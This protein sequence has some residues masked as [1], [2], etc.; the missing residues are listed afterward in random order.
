MFDS[1]HCKS[2]LSP[3]LGFFFSEEKSCLESPDIEN[4]QWGK[5]P[6]QETREGIVGPR[7]THKVGRWVHDNPTARLRGRPRW[8]VASLCRKLPPTLGTRWSQLWESKERKR[9][10]TSV[11]GRASKA[12]G[13][14][15]RMCVG[16]ASNANLFCSSRRWRPKLRG[17]WRLRRRTA[18]PLRVTSVRA[19]AWEG[20]FGCE[21]M[22][23]CGGGGQESRQLTQDGSAAVWRHQHFLKLNNRGLLTQARLS[24][25][26]WD[27]RPR[28]SASE[29]LPSCIRPHQVVPPA[30]GATR[31]RSTAGGAA[32][33]LI[34]LARKFL[35]TFPSKLIPRL[36][37]ELLLKSSPRGHRRGKGIHAAGRPRAEEQ[38]ISTASAVQ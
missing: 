4:R 32:N 1:S 37:H 14:S 31:G 18:R 13:H 25:S 26:L 17:G 5:R 29:A 28:R 23:V 8:A 12:G 34:F 30:I 10:R 11:Y 19:G 3:L 21:K 38:R 27:A 16:G 20:Q 33:L 6:A 9:K 22:R 35:S 2:S 36:F 15:V 24:V 7:C